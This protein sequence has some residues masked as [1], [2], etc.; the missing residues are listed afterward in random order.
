M[1]L[2]CAVGWDSRLV[3]YTSGFAV[4]SEMGQQ[5]SNIHLWFCCVQWDG[6][7]GRW[8]YFDYWAHEGEEGER[9]F[10]DPDDDDDND[11]YG[12]RR[13]SFLRR[14]ERLRAK[15][16]KADCCFRNLYD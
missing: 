7:V 6:T 13:R 8:Q 3:I 15:E 9:R 5:T 11:S 2:L 1:I 14:S 4:C 16:E 12:F 10:D